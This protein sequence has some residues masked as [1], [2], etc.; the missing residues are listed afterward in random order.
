[1][2]LID[3]HPDIYGCWKIGTN[4]P[5]QSGGIVW[6]LHFFDPDLLKSVEV[7]VYIYMVCMC[8]C[9]YVYVYVCK[10][11][12]VYIYTYAVCCSVLQVG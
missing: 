4:I 6:Q 9:T 2:G 12:Y 11:T 7:S 1:M 3:L 8:M 10:Y 5:L